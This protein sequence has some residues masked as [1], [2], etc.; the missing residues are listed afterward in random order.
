M[1]SEHDAVFCIEVLDGAD[2]SEAL[3]ERFGRL[4][5]NVVGVKDGAKISTQQFG[6]SAD[7]ESQRLDQNGERRSRKLLFAI[8]G[9]Q[10]ELGK[11]ITLQR[12]HLVIE[13]T[14]GVEDPPMLVAVCRIAVTVLCCDARWRQATQ[15]AQTCARVG[16]KV[17]AL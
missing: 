16:E 13:Q 11:W 2:D 15:H 14:E 5:E 12:Q 10:L 17:T 6:E 9:D 1:R 4:A 8:G 7:V 3:S